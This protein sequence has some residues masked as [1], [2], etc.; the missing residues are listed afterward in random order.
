MWALSR[1]W[2]SCIALQT[3][4]KRTPLAV[5]SRA[6]S[7]SLQL[8]AR[9]P[10]VRWTRDPMPPHPI[11]DPCLTHF[12]VPPLPRHVIEVPSVG[13]AKLD[14]AAR[15]NFEHARSPCIAARIVGD[16]TLAL[17][18]ANGAEVSCHTSSGRYS[19]PGC[20]GDTSYMWPYGHFSSRL[21]VSKRRIDS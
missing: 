15:T 21:P 20:T 18:T 1:Q 17:E 5:L 19:V 14:T 13:I 7:E 6:L 9:V 8:S 11:G 3:I 12:F 10:V 4:S 2:N 16:H